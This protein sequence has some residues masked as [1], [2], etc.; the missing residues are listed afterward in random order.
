M[1]EPA[2]RG[3][4]DTVN[5]NRIKRTSVGVVQ[6]TMDDVNTL[7]R[8]LHAYNLNNN[9]A[10]ADAVQAEQDWTSLQGQMT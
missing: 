4:R 9:N 7:V 1:G 5:I 6:V 8:M 10:E 2:K 3:I